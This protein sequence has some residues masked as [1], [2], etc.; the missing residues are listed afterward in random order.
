MTAADG[1]PHLGLVV[2]GPGDANALPLLLRRFMEARADYRDLLGKP[3]RCNGRDKA[4]VPRGIESYVSVAAARPGCRAV[5]VVLDS[6]GDA[7]C[8]LGPSL[9][10]RVQKNTRLPVAV[11]LADRCW[12][13]W[14]YASIETLEIGNGLKCS[15]ESGGTGVIKRAL[16]PGKY[17]K[18][19]WQPRLT[20]RVDINLAAGRSRSL[21]RMLQCF[22]SL[23][24]NIAHS[25]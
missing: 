2:E 17:V 9:L 16:L 22:T 25:A 6:E 11:S 3:V 10:E 24:E 8:R 1:G 15:E 23:I 19:T 21:A 4:L 7:V 18:P 12:E 20:V 14:L 5:L 13:D